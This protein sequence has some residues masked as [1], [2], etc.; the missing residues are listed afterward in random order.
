VTGALEYAAHVRGNP[1][2]VATAVAAILVSSAA[3]ANGR[4]PNAD[5]LIVDPIN[6]RHLVLRATFGTLVSTDRGSRWSW[7][8]EEAIGYTGDPAMTVLADGSLLH[9]F[10]GN[11]MVSEADGCSFDRVP[12][13]AEGRNAIDVTLDPVDPSHA[14]VLTSGLNGRLQAGLLEVSAT[15]TMPLLVSDDF[16]PSTVEVARSR[17]ERMYV[18]GFDGSLQA[19]LLVSDDRGQSWSPR[20][21]RPYSSLRMYLSAIDPVD[22]DTLYIRVDDGTTDHL[23]VSRDAGSSFADVLTIATDMLGFALSPDGSRVAAGGPGQALSV[24]STADFVFSPAAGVQSLRCLTWAEGGLYACA[25]ESIDNWTVAVSTDAGQSFTP[26][27]HVQ[28]LEPLECGAAT[29]AGLV[30]P[31]AWLE[32][33]AQIGA[34]LVPDGIPNS[35]PSS[36]PT[37]KADSSCAATPVA[38]AHSAVGVSVAS[39]LLGALLL[40]RRRQMSNGRS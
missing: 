15:A 18:V 26:L 31:Q 1:V 30:C 28:D 27:W 35:G 17:P 32:V 24:A 2:G 34:D 9:A 12:L 25:Q 5:M 8:C 3:L 4:Y 36:P 11:V 10:L 37:A 20:P 7:I 29:S 19:T 38:N 21:I 6:P 22:P 14:W 13:A 39:S 16:V 40:R 33:S 23:L